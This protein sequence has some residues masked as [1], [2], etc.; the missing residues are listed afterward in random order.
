MVKLRV[1]N[2]TK[3]YNGKK[4][5]DNINAPKSEAYEQ[6][7]ASYHQHEKSFNEWQKEELHKGL[8][9]LEKYFYD[10]WD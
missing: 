6:A 8:V 2:L 9:L 7:M 1:K 5:L 4:V 3:V 10:L